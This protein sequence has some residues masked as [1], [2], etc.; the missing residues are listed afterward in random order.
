MLRIKT[1]KPTYRIRYVPFRVHMLRFRISICFNYSKLRG[2]HFLIKCMQQSHSWKANRSSANQTI[3]PPPT[4]PLYGKGKSSPYNRPLRPKGVVEV[5]L[6]SFSNLGA[7]WCGVGQHYAPAVLP[8]WERPCTHCTGGWVGPRGRYGRVRKISPTPPGFDPRT[9]QPVASRYTDWAI[10]AHFPLY[11]TPSFITLF[12]IAHHL[13]LSWARSIHSK[14][15]SCLL[16][17]H[18]IIILSSM[19]WSSEWSRFYTLS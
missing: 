16:K 4:F 18:F 8:S 11:G 3:H 13:S 6:Y 17:I 7:R 19:P 10:P 15:I 5:Q 12:T 9:V 1:G 14:P 2:L